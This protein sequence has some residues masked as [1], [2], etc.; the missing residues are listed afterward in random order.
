MTVEMYAGCL[1]IWKSKL[2]MEIVLSTTESEIISL[3]ATLK[4]MIPLWK[5]QLR[6]ERKR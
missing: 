1:V 5:C 6:D 3:S 4:V 2:Q